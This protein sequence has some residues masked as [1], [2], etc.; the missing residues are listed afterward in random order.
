[1]RLSQNSGT[2]ATFVSNAYIR[3]LGFVGIVPGVILVALEKAAACVYHRWGR[4]WKQLASKIAQCMY[5]F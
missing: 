5:Y 3:I 2:L 1:M 4:Y